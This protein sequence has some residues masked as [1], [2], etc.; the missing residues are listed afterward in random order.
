MKYVSGELDCDRLASM[1]ILDIIRENYEVS[2]Y[3]RVKMDH[4]RAG[5]RSGWE[6]RVP[7]D[8]IRRAN[9]AVIFLEGLGIPCGTPFEKRGR[10]VVPIYGKQ[11]CRDFL[12]LVRPSV[13][14]RIARPPNARDLRFKDD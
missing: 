11:R 10:M 2:G 6:L 7:F 1:S 13:K 3:T 12:K 4:R 9:R 5:V 8:H 14:T